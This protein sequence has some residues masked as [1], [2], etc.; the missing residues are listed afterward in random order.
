M[1]I[2][3]LPCSITSST[4]RDARR[5]TRDDDRR[6]ETHVA[7]I[8]PFA[9]IR[10]SRKKPDISNQIAPPYDVLDDAGK[11]KLTARSPTNIV[12]IDLPFMPPKSVGPDEVYAGADATFQ[13]WLRDGVLVRDHRPALYPHTQTYE[14]AGKTFHRRGF[15]ALV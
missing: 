8:R 5:A 15:I 11:A 3:Y 12:G 2:A 4:R 7:Q 10:Y 13:S 6:E 9:G 14:H 1:G